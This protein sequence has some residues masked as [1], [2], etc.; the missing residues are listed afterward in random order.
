MAPDY[1]YIHPSLK[2]KFIEAFKD[3]IVKQYSKNPKESSN[4][5]RMINSLHTER[6]AKL[7]RDCEEQIIFGDLKEVDVDA[8]Y[9]PPIIVE[10]PS[11]DSDLMKEEIFGPVLPILTY[12]RPQE[13]ID[14]IRRLGSPLT[15]YFFGDNDS[16]IC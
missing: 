7:V 10:N 11:L 3:E 5:S 8:K 12:E 16:V 13:I 1:L 14:N 9:I 6:V 4:Y 2:D 15:V